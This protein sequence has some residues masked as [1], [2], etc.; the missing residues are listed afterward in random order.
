MKR[1]I[2][3]LFYGAGLLVIIYGVKELIIL[4]KSAYKVVR[5]KINKI[6]LTTIDIILYLQITNNSD[7]SAQIKNEFF[8][9]F[10][11][12]K[13]VSEIKSADLI[14]INSNGN[15]VLPIPIKIN[16]DQLIKVA[17]N[18]ISNILNDKSKIKLE[19]KG[20]LSLQVGAIDLKNY[21]I[22][23]NYTLQDLIDMS[24]D[25]QE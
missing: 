18:N 6:S 7:I 8:E 13:K 4:Y 16:S 24:K 14:H 11:N 23:I 22:D 17:A 5:T 20:Y 12:D 3:T 9:V 1:L 25:K 21:A 2:V 15:T 10:I 19:I